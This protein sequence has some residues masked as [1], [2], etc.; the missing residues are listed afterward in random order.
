MPLDS[1]SI[2]QRRTKPLPA[3]EAAT[4]LL[5]HTEIELTHEHADEQQ[6]FAGIWEPF[7]AGV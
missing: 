1:L 7:S 3:P 2:A 4:S 6:W 5:L